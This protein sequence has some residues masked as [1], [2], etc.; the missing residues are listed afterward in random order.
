MSRGSGLHGAGFGRALLAA[1]LFGAATPASKP[2]VDAIGPLAL[3]GLLYLGAALGVLPAALRGDGLRALARLDRRNIFRLAGAVLLG[4]V[5]GPVLLLAALAR[6]PAA[7]VSLASG[8]EGVFTALLG[9]LF[10][11]DALGLRGWLGV[12][13]ASGAA[14][15]LA[16][17]GDGFADA[18]PL[19]LVA[20]AC[21]CW[22]FDNHLTALLDGLTPAAATLAKGL[23]AGV[24]NL[25]LAAL[26]APRL[27][28]P[29]ELAAALAI[30]ALGYGASIV[31]YVTAAQEI[32]AT[33]AQTAFATAP[34]LGALVAFA[35]LGEPL[36]GG[37]LGAGLLLATSIALLLASSHVH[38]HRH[39]AMDHVHAHRHDDGHHTHAHPGLPP[40]TR[41]SHRHRHEALSHEHSHA[42]DLHHRHPH[43]DG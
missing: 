23:A 36:S 38:V 15:L 30:G 11:H 5:A 31:L 7:S 10:F 39:E 18:L 2:L 22:A 37:Q 35:A 19:L 43:G 3:A 17:G 29:V 41:H 20:A 28:G 8:L 9:V 24:T 33:R 27:P 13:A 16:G 26:L 25:G 14:L 21:V 1:L 12:A 42:P 6:A 4:G 34:F 32:G 40:A